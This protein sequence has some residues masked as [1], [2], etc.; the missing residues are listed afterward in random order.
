MCI[1]ALYGHTA[2]VCFSDA[3]D[4]RDAPTRSLSKGLGEHVGGRLG[5]GRRGGNEGGGREGGD[6]GRGG[7]LGI[8]GG[9]DGGDGLKPAKGAGSSGGGGVGGG[10]GMNVAGITQWNHPVVCRTTRPKSAAILSA[11]LY[12]RP[13]SPRC[14]DISARREFPDAVWVT[15]RCVDRGLEP[16][17]GSSVP[18]FDVGCRRVVLA[19]AAGAV[20]VNLDRRDGASPLKS[21]RRIHSESKS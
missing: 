21:G 18:R 5:G 12:T 19:V 1:F 15:R 16:W 17:V 2:T 4:A 7:F 10:G 14:S 6:L 3:T 11:C 9:I 20:D 8:G 13:R